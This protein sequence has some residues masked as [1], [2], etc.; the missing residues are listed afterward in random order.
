VPCTNGAGSDSAAPESGAR[1]IVGTDER[2]VRS[3]KPQSPETQLAIRAEL[4]GSDTLH[5]YRGI[6]PVPACTAAPPMRGNEPGGPKPCR[7]RG[8]KAAA[9]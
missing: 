3:F 5:A 9:S 8:A 6:V 1:K 7:G 4:T 2:D